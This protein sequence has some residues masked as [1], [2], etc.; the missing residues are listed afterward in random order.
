MSLSDS[1]KEGNIYIR[2]DDFAFFE[3][4]YGSL[5]GGRKE[6][7][8]NALVRNGDKLKIVD[9]DVLDQ[10]GIEVYELIDRRILKEALKEAKN[11]GKGNGKV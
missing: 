1:G 3:R 8:M 10:G 6:E 9:N 2:K 11:G 4:I 5:N 7:F